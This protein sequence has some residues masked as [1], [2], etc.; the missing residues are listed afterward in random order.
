MNELDKLLKIQY[1]CTIC[2]KLLFNFIT[3]VVVLTYIALFIYFAVISCNCG[4]AISES[5]KKSFFYGAK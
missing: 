3:H 5:L 2:I 1:I 4:V